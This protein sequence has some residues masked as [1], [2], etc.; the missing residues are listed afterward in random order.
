MSLF[1][2]Q[3]QIQ[4]FT[5]GSNTRSNLLHNLAGQSHL[6]DVPQHETL[7]MPLELDYRQSAR[8]RQT[9]CIPRA[10][11]AGIFPSPEDQPSGA[12]PFTSGLYPFPL[13]DQTGYD[14]QSPLPLLGPDGRPVQGNMNRVGRDYQVENCDSPSPR[15]KELEAT[16]TQNQEDTIMHSLK[17]VLGEGDDDVDDGLFGVDTFTMQRQKSKTEYMRRGAT[18]HFNRDFAHGII[19]EERPFHEDSGSNS[20]QQ[21][22]SIFAGGFDRK[23]SDV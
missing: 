12:A 11:F 21:S 10:P 6:H 23:I 17:Q 16:F 14:D 8:Q 19:E 20:N 1:V 15:K 4:S 18:F 5:G 22:Q 2:A 3:R 7:F 13:Q 9:E